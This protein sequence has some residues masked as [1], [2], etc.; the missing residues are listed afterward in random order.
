MKHF[1]DIENKVWDSAKDG[2]IK[3]FIPPDTD[4]PVTVFLQWFEGGWN[5]VYEVRIGSVNAGSE[6]RILAEEVFGAESQP[7]GWTVANISAFE[8]SF[9]KGTLKPKSPYYSDIPI[10]FLER[11]PSIV[12][13]L[14]RDIEGTRQAVQLL[15]NE[16]KLLTSAGSLSKFWQDAEDSERAMVAFKLKELLY[17]AGVHAYRNVAYEL[18]SFK[19]KKGEPISLSAF[20]R[21]CERAEKR[22]VRQ[23]NTTRGVKK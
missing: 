12:S 2:T 11:V 20:N 6:N 18:L 13:A 4:V 19:N 17:Q 7:S 23:Q 21:L 14:Q 5:R 10:E 8:P 1:L 16:Y 22:E 3:E 9:G 15:R